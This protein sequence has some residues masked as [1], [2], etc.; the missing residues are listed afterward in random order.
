MY[1]HYNN[2][3]GN[4]EFIM[5]CCKKEQ[6]K[7][8]KSMIVFYFIFLTNSIMQNIKNNPIKIHIKVNDIFFAIYTIS[9]IFY[10][11]L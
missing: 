10:L 11:P 5:R 9:D 4:M 7:T 6:I 8:I 2:F 1:G 3:P